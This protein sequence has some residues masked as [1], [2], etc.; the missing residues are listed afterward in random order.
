MLEGDQ[1]RNF[2]DYYNKV[3]LPLEAFVK[4]VNKNKD[5]SID[6]TINL[7]GNLISGKL[8]GISKYYQELKNIVMTGFGQKED[9]KSL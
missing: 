4:I 1:N 9:M 8:I 6:V 5:S 3:L 2:L 7:H